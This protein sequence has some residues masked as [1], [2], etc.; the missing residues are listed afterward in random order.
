M[1]NHKYKFAYL[2]VL[3]LLNSCKSNLP[4]KLNES[5]NE[6]DTYKAEFDF[7]NDVLDLENKLSIIRFGSIEK[8]YD[9]SVL[10]MDLNYL[11]STYIKAKYSLVVE[12]YNLNKFPNNND[13]HRPT[14][15]SF[16]FWLKSDK[17]TLKKINDSLTFY[18]HCSFE[19]YITNF[20]KRNELEHFGEGFGGNKYV[21]YFGSNKDFGVVDNQS[22][23]TLKHYVSSLFRQISINEYIQTFSLKNDWQKYKDTV[24]Y[25]FDNFDSI[26]REKNMILQVDW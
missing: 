8:V 1:L 9:Y 16:Y 14:V 19:N 22:S 23:I 18:N 3:I 26:S 7:L 2:V 20:V 12:P 15:M 5:G 21:L 6:C 10:T 4:E 25:M 17:V 24:A 11:D 13:L